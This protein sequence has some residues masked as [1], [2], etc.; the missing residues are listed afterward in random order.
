MRISHI[1][2]DL[3]PEAGGPSITVTHLTDALSHQTFTEVTLLSQCLTDSSVV[4]PA[5]NSKV[6]RIIVDSSHKIAL[7]L[8]LPLNNLL[9]SRLSSY[10]P[11]IIHGHGLWHPISYWRSQTAKQYNIPLVIHSHGMLE[12]WALNYHKLKKQIALQL[13]QKKTYNRLKYCSPPP[14]GSPEHPPIWP[15]S[16]HSYY[17]QRHS[18][19]HARISSISS[20]IITS[21]NSSIPQSHPSQKG[22]D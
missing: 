22:A 3:A 5:P 8:G 19:P 20:G 10:P 6:D 11:D 13:Y 7:S 18:F 4:A 12:P 2:A 17:P 16:A 9:R 1:I 14:P 21:P 15:A